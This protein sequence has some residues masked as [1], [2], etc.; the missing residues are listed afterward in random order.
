M[1]ISCFLPTGFKNA[2]SFVTLVKN[3]LGSNSGRIQK[4]TVCWL[5]FGREDVQINIS[6]AL[7]PHTHTEETG[8]ELL[9]RRVCFSV[10]CSP[11][12]LFI[13]HHSE[14]APVFFTGGS[15]FTAIQRRRWLFPFSR[16]PCNKSCLFFFTSA[17]RTA[18]RMSRSFERWP[19]QRH[20]VWSTQPSSCLL[21]EG[22]IPPHPGMRPRGRYVV[23]S[24]HLFLILIFFS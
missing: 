6:S 23:Q 21:G 24:G 9:A 16:L 14:M 13:C 15:I 4:Q 7:G 22:N 2:K 19:V 18:V 10:L 8:L 17:S 3:E 5:L 11:P 12:A 1:R 20:F